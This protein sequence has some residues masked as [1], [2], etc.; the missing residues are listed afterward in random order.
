[1][2]AENAS[3]PVDM[4]H[5]IATASGGV[6]KPNDG[7]GSFDGLVGDEV[8]DGAPGGVESST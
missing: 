4:E 1:M 5:S 7:F 2:H 3:A 6:V 8:I